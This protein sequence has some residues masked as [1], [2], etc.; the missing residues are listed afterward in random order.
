MSIDESAFLTEFLAETNLMLAQIDFN[1]KLYDLIFPIKSHFLKQ[2]ELLSFSM[3]RYCGANAPVAFLCEWYYQTLLLTS[4]PLPLIEEN[5]NYF[6]KKVPIKFRGI[7]GMPAMIEA[8]IDIFVPQQLALLQNKSK[9]IIDSL[10]IK[11][12]YLSKYLSDQ[13]LNQVLASIY[14]VNKRKYVENLSL[15]E[16]LDSQ[17]SSTSFVQIA[18]PCLLGFC[19]NFNQ[20]GN[21]INA[22]N[23]KWVFLEEVLKNI[24]LLHQL[25]KSRKF[26]EFLYASMLDEKGEF[27]W[28][29]MDEKKR[30]QKILASNDVKELARS[31]K[32]KIYSSALQSLQSLSLPDNN[33]Q[34]L[35]ELLD[36]A[37][38]VP[39]N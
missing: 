19:F 16:Y 33:S 27:E 34:M 23:I 13:F 18:L 24:S 11:F 38:M 30:L 36:W 12:P 8:D 32:N 26:E 10:V 9:T 1:N 21:P 28:L 7:I 15:S 31:H 3:A 2:K 39:V 22:N 4:N 6:T 29:Q 35:R 17:S 20:E 37:K 25:N 14:S 5:R